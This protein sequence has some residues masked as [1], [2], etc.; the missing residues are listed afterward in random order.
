M[1]RVVANLEKPF[2]LL[3]TRIEHSLLPALFQSDVEQVES[4]LMM[5]SCC[6]GGSGTC[7]PVATSAIAF[8]SSIEATKILSE[9]IGSG[10]T[11]E[12]SKHEAQMSTARN[13]AREIQNDMEETTLLLV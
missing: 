7:D 9:S 11:L 1:Q 13:Q 8:E 4:S 6:N 12:I 3:K 5:L 10:T 2:A